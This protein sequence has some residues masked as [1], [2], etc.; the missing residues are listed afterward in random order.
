GD[1]HPGR[2]GDKRHGARRARVDLEHVDVVVLDRELDVHQPNNVKSARE[3]DGL[4]LDFRDGLGREAV[5]GQRAG[6]VAG[7]NPGLLDVFHDAGYVDLRAVGDRI[8]I[9]L[10]RVL[11]IAVYEHR[12]RS[13]DND[14]TA[15]V[16]G[17]RRG[18]V[19]D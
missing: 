7:V 1:R 2:L 5:R 8:D 9:D 11:Q 16:T 3:C 6:A 10:D 19:D 17:E 15:D 18:I 12:A 13:R 14:R 4:A